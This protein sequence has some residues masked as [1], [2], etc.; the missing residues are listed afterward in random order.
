MLRIYS[1]CNLNMLRI[2][3]K[4]NLNILRIYSKCNPNIFTTQ[5]FCYLKIRNYIKDCI[6][7]YYNLC[8]P[9]IPYVSILSYVPVQCTLS[10]HP[11]HLYDIFQCRNP[12]T[13]RLS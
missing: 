1:K 6:N 3:S 12:C 4:Y 8:S 7:Y 5:R 9:N 10:V 11:K 2:Y 13:A